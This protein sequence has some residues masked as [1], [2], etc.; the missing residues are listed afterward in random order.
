MICLPSSTTSPTNT[1]AIPAI[2]ITTFG[3]TELPPITLCISY[4][5]RKKYNALV[6]DTKLIISAYN[7]FVEGGGGGG[8]IAATDR[9]SKFEQ[10]LAFKH[11]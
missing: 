1:L 8:G 6:H 4:K 5:K 9:C 2:A 3:G 11:S 7:R 10:L